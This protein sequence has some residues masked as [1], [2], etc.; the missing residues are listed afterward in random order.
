MS[1]VDGIRMRGHQGQVHEGHVGDAMAEAEGVEDVET[2]KNHDQFGTFRVTAETAPYGQADEDV[3]EDATAKDFQRRQVHPQ[4]GSFRQGLGHGSRIEACAIED[5]R[6][7][8]GAEPVA[9]ITDDQELHDVSGGHG[10]APQAVIEDEGVTG[11]HFRASY[12]DQAEGDAERKAHDD[13]D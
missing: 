7:D 9:E 8:E 3:A 12:D 13:M 10:L 5:D 11:E 6:Q 4:G 1:H 2:P